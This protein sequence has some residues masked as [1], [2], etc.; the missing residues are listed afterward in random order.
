VT[1]TRHV[2]RSAGV[3]LLCAWCTVSAQAPARQILLLQSVERG[4]SVLD[5][6]TAQL[7]ATISEKPSPPVRFTEFVLNPAGFPGIPDDAIVAYLQAAFIDDRKPDLVITAGGAAA[8]FARR[9][10]RDMFP[11]TPVL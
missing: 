6:F 4:T 10:R 7:R 1:L 2:V 5:Y 8:I 9:H 3:I 11:D